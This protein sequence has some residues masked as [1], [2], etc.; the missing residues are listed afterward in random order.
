MRVIDL[1]EA[2]FRKGLERS[3]L[4]TA[5]VDKIM[6]IRQGIDRINLMLK[7]LV[8]ERESEDYQEMD[9]Q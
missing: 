4:D 8:G 6:Q 5:L 9:E 3:K 1:S 2:R 7:E